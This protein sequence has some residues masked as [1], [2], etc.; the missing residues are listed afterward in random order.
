MAYLVCIVI[1]RGLS[2]RGFRVAPGRITAL[3]LFV[4]AS[5]I[6]LGLG[7][8]DY[9]R[10]RDGAPTIIPTLGYVLLMFTLLCWG[11]RF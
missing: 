9:L 5:V 7:I 3:P 1:L 6:Q 2:K 10:I 8:I 11:C 4:L